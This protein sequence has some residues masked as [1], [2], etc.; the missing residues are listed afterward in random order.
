LRYQTLGKPQER[1]SP[2]F[3]LKLT[4]AF[5]RR[6]Q[7]AIPFA[8]DLVA[9]AAPRLRGAR[10]GAFPPLGAIALGGALMIANIAH[11]RRAIPV[12]AVPPAAAAAPI[13][14]VALDPPKPAAPA[15]VAQKATL[16]IDT[17]PLAAIPEPAKQKPKHKRHAR[18]AKGLDNQP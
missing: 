8:R 17:T 5:R 6:A 7:A 9:S 10:A 1:P 16:R 3:T 14:A 15:P 13:Q 12:V 11:D 4:D 2:V 18:K